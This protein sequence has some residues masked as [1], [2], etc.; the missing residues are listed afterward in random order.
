M[1]EIVMHHTCNMDYVNANFTAYSV[2]M[3][4]TEVGSSNGLENRG[5]SKRLIVRCD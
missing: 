2:K 1:A 4:P 3:V 5:D